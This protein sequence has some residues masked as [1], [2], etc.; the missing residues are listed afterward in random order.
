M[1]KRVPAVRASHC[2]LTEDLDSLCVQLTL[3]HSSILINLLYIPPGHNC[4]L[5][6]DYCNSLEPLN[7]QYKDIT[8]LGDFNIPKINGTHLDFSVAR[9]SAGVINNTMCEYNLTS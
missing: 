9:S 1:H 6:T 2:R 5:F 3:S 8:I 7:I 4:Q